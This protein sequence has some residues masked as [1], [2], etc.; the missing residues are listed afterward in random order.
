MCPHGGR[1][2]R[3]PATRLDPA[4]SCGQCHQRP[5]TSNFKQYRMMTPQYAAAGGELEPR[6]RLAKLNIESN[7]AL[8]A[9]SGSAAFRRWRCSQRVVKSPASLAPWGNQT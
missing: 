1:S 9:S 3:I 8:P 4:P 7:R 5:F 2:N 6:V